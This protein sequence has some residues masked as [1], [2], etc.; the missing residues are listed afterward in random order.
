MVSFS[1][2]S[3]SGCCVVLLSLVLAGC[4]SEDSDRLRGQNVPEDWPDEFVMG[5]FGGDDANEVMER[6]DP[7][8][9]YL[10]ER[11]Q[12][13]V[14]L[15]TGTSYTAVVEAMRAGRVDAM[16]IGPFAYIL[17]VQEAGAEAIAILVSVDGEQ[18]RYAADTETNYFSAIITVKG[19]GIRSIDDLRGRDFNYVDPASMSGHLAPRAFFLSRGIDPDKD[20]NTFFAGSHPTS[21]LTVKEGRSDAG[22]TTLGYLYRMHDQGLIDFC[23]FKEGQISSEEVISQNYDACPEGHIAII[24][25]TDPIPATPLSVRSTLPESLK[26]HVREALLDIKENEQNPASLVRYYVD[27]TEELG[28]NHLDEYYNPL[29]E[30]AKLLDL[31]LESLID[32]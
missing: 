12:I 23:G 20:M 29:R 19:S 4:G 6:N 10:E 22:A 32:Q 7:L 8:R 15:F 1:Y 17:A 31:E 2:K 14:R 24:G 11:L 21:V 25:L 16:A 27:P 5:F 18:S 28:L 3:I 30:M 9:D 13:P 26:E